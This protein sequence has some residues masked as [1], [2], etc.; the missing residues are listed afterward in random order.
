MAVRDLPQFLGSGDLL[1][2]N[3]T[4]VLPARLFGL[5]GMRG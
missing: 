1:V 5:R 3:D 4:K 2:F